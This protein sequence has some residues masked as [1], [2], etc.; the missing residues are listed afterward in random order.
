M[1]CIAFLVY[2]HCILQLY[3]HVSVCYGQFQGDCIM[4]TLQVLLGDMGGMWI[5]VQCNKKGRSC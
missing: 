3:Q 5:V 2:V 1:C 4:Y